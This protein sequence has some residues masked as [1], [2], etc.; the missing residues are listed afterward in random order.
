MY[1]MDGRE[2]S[3]ALKGARPG[4]G[5]MR[6][7]HIYGRLQALGVVGRRFIFRRVEARLVLSG[8]LEGA[9]ET[10]INATTAFLHSPAHTRGSMC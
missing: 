2:P 7:V 10:M 4:V 9:M 5:R 1:W 3:R 8:S 6:G